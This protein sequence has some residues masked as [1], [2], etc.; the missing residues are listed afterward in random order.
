MKKKTLLETNP[1]LK[2]PQVRKRLIAKSV[3]TS[4]AVEGID[5][6]DTIERHVKIPQKADKRIYKA[7]GILSHLTTK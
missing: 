4:C 3:K 1:Y 5:V 6:E 2:D 7:G